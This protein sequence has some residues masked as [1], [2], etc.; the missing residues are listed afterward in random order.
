MVRP[1]A[2]SELTMTTG[3]AEYSRTRP[4]RLWLYFVAVLVL[5]MV[6]VGGATRLTE[7]GLSITE[8]KPV[9]GVLP[10]LRDAQWLA[11]FQKYQ[12]IPQYH[13]LNAAMSLAEFK[14]IYWWEWTHRLLGRLIGVAFLLPFLWFLWRG[15]LEP[16]LRPR[17]WFIFA[18]G[19]AQGVVGWWMVASG[20]SDRVEVSHY[21]LA[22]HLILACAIYVAL[23][24]TAQRL[25]K[26]QLQPA[27]PR[28]RFAALALLVLVLLQIYLGALVAGMRAGYAYNT[29]PLIDGTLLPNPAQLFF[30]TPWWRNFFDNALTVQFDHRIVAYLILVCALWHAFD[31]ARAE[32]TAAARAGAFVL[33]AV[34]ALQAALGIATLLLVVPLP[35]ALLHQAMAML[36]LTIGVLHAAGMTRRRI[37]HAPSLRVG[38]GW[39]EG[40]TSAA[41]R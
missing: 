27:A 37:R 33:L 30:D 19:A 29:W 15:W 2:T 5:A 9:M 38:E 3:L 31:V 28:V 16:S 21:R 35:L 32:Q 10:P 40:S 17:L 41:L 39:G 6:L 18:L 14:T 12:A 25:D 13:A 20:L 22:T 11:A 24:W 8:W 23:L 34:V 7:S 36:V 1:L 4:I 26:A